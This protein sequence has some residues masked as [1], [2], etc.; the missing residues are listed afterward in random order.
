MEYNKFIDNVLNR[1]CV[2]PPLRHAVQR[3]DLMD[4]LAEKIENI[5]DEGGRTSIRA[6]NNW[7]VIHGPPGVGKT[8]LVVDTLRLKPE[9]AGH[10]FDRIFW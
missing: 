7:L 2:P 1:G 5:A 6:Q 9:F 8:R 3:K 10:H 4:I